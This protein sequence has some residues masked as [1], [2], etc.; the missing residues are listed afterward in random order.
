MIKPKQ[1]LDKVPKR[2]SGTRNPKPQTPNP[3]RYLKQVLVLEVAVEVL[4]REFFDLSRRH[5]MHRWRRARRHRGHRFQ[6]VMLPG[7]VSLHRWAHCHV[8]DRQRNDPSVR[9]LVEC[10]GALPANN[11]PASDLA[12]P[13]RLPHATLFLEEKSSTSVIT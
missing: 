11:G 6:Q 12:H 1:R 3:A 4:R 5:R 2:C 10:N 9:D 13:D 7:P 8:G